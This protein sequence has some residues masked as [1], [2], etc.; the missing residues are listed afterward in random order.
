MFNKLKAHYFNSTQVKAIEN[1]PGC[2]VFKQL[3]SVAQNGHTT[4]HVIMQYL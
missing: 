3:S 2:S 1:D 4:V